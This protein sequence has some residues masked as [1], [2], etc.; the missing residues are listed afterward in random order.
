N[1][2][3]AQVASDRLAM[4]VVDSSFSMRAGSRLSDAKREA[5][6]VLASRGLAQHVQVLALDSELHVLTQPGQ[7]P[8]A[9]RAAIEA[10]QPSDS[11][12]SSGELVRA[13]RL[14]AD[15]FHG[16]IDLHLFS[17]MQRSSMAPSALDMVLPDNVRLTL[18]PV[19][20]AAAPNWAVES[21]TAP[22]QLWGNPRE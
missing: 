10:G 9:Q 13:V 2:P 11:R 15:S 8:G 1:R 16:T 22:A 21:V 19:S 17:D 18:H 14:T 20:K 4:L 3:A 5:L 7:D 12:S 6:S